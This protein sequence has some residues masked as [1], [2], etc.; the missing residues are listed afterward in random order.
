MVPTPDQLNP[1]VPDNMFN[2][3]S[4]RPPDRSPILSTLQVMHLGGVDACARSIKAQEQQQK[5]TSGAAF[6]EQLKALVEGSSSAR[7]RVRLLLRHMRCVP[8]PVAHP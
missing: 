2:H 8:A 1:E 3:G 4:P 6:V 5:P 7:A